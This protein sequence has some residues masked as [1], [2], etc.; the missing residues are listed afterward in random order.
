[1]DDLSQRKYWTFFLTLIQLFLTCRQVHRLRKIDLKSGGNTNLGH[2]KALSIS[3]SLTGVD[4][5][6]L[7]SYLVLGGI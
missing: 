7:K 3:R 2:S 1:M 4:F 6:K 5:E